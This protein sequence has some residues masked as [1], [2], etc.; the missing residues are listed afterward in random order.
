[1]IESA[2]ADLNARERH[3][4]RTKEA[5]ERGIR[6]REGLKERLLRE[7]ATDLA[8]K[9]DKCGEPL[10]LVCCHCGGR[11]QVAIACKRRWCP[12]CAW[13]VQWDRLSRFKVAADCMQWPLFVTLTV[14]NSEDPECIRELRACWSKMR[15]R[16]LIAD[17]V[18][19]GVSTIEVTNTGNGWH[20]HLHILCDCEW[21]A[22]HTPKPRWGDS[23]AVK[24]QKYMHAADELGR[25][26]AHVTKQE[27]AI[28]KAIRKPPGD[29]LRY[30]M[31][32]AVKGSDLIESPDPIAPLIRVM[33]R[34]RMVSAFGSLHGNIPSD[35]EDERPAVACE[36][37]GEIKSFVPE[38]VEDRARIH[39]YDRSHALR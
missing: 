22:V 25:I 33:S 3:E 29:V 17:K 35:P 2:A 13:L 28:V 36:C 19:G 31:K 32:Y 39:A 5:R 15:R 7:G 18:K 4:L 16:K 14:E 23:E 6:E 38:A 1:M 21:L 20:P 30:A 9:L 27:I 8:M 12:S 34:S 37:C 26:W 11:K 10:R 24:K